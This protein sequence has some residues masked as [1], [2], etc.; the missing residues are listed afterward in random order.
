MPKFALCIFVLCCSCL[1][2]QNKHPD[3]PRTDTFLKAID[4]LRKEKRI[5]GLAV[6]VVHNQQIIISTGLGVTDITTQRPVTNT[7]PFDIASVT[8]PLSAVFILQLVEQGVIDLDQPIAEYSKWPD[9]C[10]AF[11]KQPSIFAKHLDCQQKTHSLRHMLTHTAENIPGQRFSYNPVVFSWASRPVMA[12]LNQSFSHAFREHIIKPL[13][14]KNTARRHRNLPLPQHINQHLAQ[15]HRLGKNGNLQL[16]PPLEKQGDGAAG[17]V[18]ASVDDLA[19]F[20]IALNAGQL[21]EPET[22]A[23]MFQPYRN[24]LNQPQPYAIGWYVERFKGLQLYWHSGLWDHAYSALYLKVPEHNLS[25]I[26]LANSQGMW[27][28]NPLDK[29]EV[30]RSAF[31]QLFF[32]H[33]LQ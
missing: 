1:H 33:F 17:G 25:L 30:Y 27:W 26:L 14:L 10:R 3:S 28:K 2:A 20:D 15:P 12:R 16:A 6:A 29:A 8:K 32:K 9:F 21:L 13:A 31:A 11:S 18:V 7:T 22:Q 5:P 4:A 23:L 19:T 24:H